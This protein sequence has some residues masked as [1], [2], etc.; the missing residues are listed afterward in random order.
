M[1]VRRITPVEEKQLTHHDL[2]G[3]VEDYGQPFIMMAEEK[4]CRERHQGHKQKKNNIDP[5][6]NAII[7]QNYAELFLMEYPEYSQ[8]EE[9]QSID[10]ELRYCFRKSLRKIYMFGWAKDL[11]DDKSQRQQSHRNGKNTVNQGFKALRAGEISDRIIVE[12]IHRKPLWL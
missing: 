11:G 7:A 4:K 9:S 12:F 5:E 6:K 2:V 1:S 3:A 8:I 10:E